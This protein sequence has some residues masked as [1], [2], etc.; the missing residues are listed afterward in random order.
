M[1]DALQNMLGRLGIIA[2]GLG[3]LIVKGTITSTGN[4]G[5]SNAPSSVTTVG[6]ATLTA[7]QLSNKTIV[8]GG[9]QTANFTDTTDTA[10]NIFAA[11]PSAVAGQ[12][13]SMFYLN[14]T[15]FAATITG[16][17]GVTGQNVF[18]PALT[19][20]EI[21]YTLVS[22]SSV[23]MAIRITGDLGNLPDYTYQTTALASGVITASLLTGGTETVLLSSGATALTTPT[24]AALLAA[25]PNG[26]AGDTWKVR[27]I[28]TNAGTLT[29]TADASITITGTLTI[30]TNTWREYIVTILTA[31]TAKMQQV[32][33]GTNS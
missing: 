15:S 10:A 7:A 9:T 13:F 28:N 18:V 8:R 6:A 2:D 16:G 19:S 14:N 27:I 21:Y 25:T 33:T 24:A 30:A 11:F 29:L 1:S 4:A 31:T 12:T 23:T 3:N 26:G 20:V 17:S 22:A 5:L 32:G